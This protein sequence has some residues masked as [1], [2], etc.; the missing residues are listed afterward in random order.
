MTLTPVAAT[1]PMVTAAPAKKLVPWIV[2]AVPP[3]G[4]PDCVLIENGRRWENSEVLP[5][6]SVAVTEM[7]APLSVVPRPADVEG[8]VARA[9]G[10][11]LAG[12]EI[13]LALDVFAREVRAG[14]A[15]VEVELVGRARRRVENAGDRRGR[16]VGHR[17]DDRKVLQVVGPRVPVPEVVRRRAVA[18]EVDADAR[19]V[20]NRIAADRVAGDRPGDYHAGSGVE[21]DQVPGARIGAS[22]GHVVG[23]ER[24]ARALVAE[25]DRPGHVR[26]DEIALDRRSRR[27]DHRDSRGGI[28]RDDVARAGC[29]AADRV[30]QAV[31]E[32]PGIPVAEGQG[33]GDVGA[34][35]VALD[36]VVRDR[37]SFRLLLT[38][39]P[40]WSFPE[41]T[42]RAAAVVPP[43]WTPVVTWP[44]AIP[45]W[46]SGSAPVPGALV[47]MRLPWMTWFVPPVVSIPTKL[48][49]MMLRAAGVVPPT[50]T[51]EMAPS[52]AMPYPRLPRPSCPWGRRR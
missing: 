29:G 4:G 1:P 46:N 16:A 28:C 34:D 10:R 23:L 14:R 7:R 51:F 22:D 49:E 32:M 43:I 48:P 41:M 6:G 2:R 33:A 52:I 3:D 38:A 19:V 36:H 26:A 31:Q 20:M 42:L 39:M 37:L 18:V 15:R 9:V 11:G 45:V 12:A 5:S 8:G 17:G 25:S 30:V 24:D 27:V 21:G 13:G 44:S 50:R 40:P 35:E 47:P